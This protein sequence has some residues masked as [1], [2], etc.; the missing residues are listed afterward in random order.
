[1]KGAI[2]VFNFLEHSAPEPGREG[3][4]D[5]WIPYGDTVA[6][7]CRQQVD[8]FKEAIDEYETELSLAEKIQA[9][10]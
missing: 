10:A 6:L 3:E 1:M 5:L 9:E 7:L 2:R 8:V 4:N